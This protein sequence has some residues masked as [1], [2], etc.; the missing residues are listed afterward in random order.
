MWPPFRDA[1]NP[2]H[3]TVAEPVTRSHRPPELRVLLVQ[4]RDPGDPMAEH[5]HGCVRRRLAGRPLAIETRNVLERELPPEA[6]DPYDAVIFGGSGDYSV[7]DPRSEPWIRGLRRVLDRVL[8]RGMPGFGLCFGHQLLGAHLGSDV[9]TADAHAELG[10]VDMRLTRHGAE[11]PIF[12]DL[13]MDF[14][15]HT[16]HSDH[17]TGVPAGV[18]LLA[19]NDALDTQAFKVDDRPFYSTQFHPDLTGVEAVSRYLAYQESLSRSE[20]VAAVAA[21]RFRPGADAAT[22]LLGRFLDAVARDKT[23]A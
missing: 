3:G 4:V 21:S 16:G 19:E 22:V 6:V 20:E 5:E 12:C 1:R 17:V 14:H 18:T 23:G 2:N 15:A 8:E 10:T 13:E 7:H 11:D 9:S